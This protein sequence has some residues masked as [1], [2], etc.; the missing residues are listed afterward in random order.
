[1][2]SPR[3]RLAF[4]PDQEA[5]VSSILRLLAVRPWLVAGRDDEA[6][7][8][9]RRNVE[10]IRA[11]FGRLGWVVVMQKDMVRLLKS[12][13]PRL[14]DW[15]ETGPDHLTCSWFFLLAAAA[16]SLPPQVA[17]G[18]FVEAAKAAAAEADVPS[19]GDRAQ[20]RAITRAIR[21]LADRGVIEETDGRID[22]YL[23][24]DDAP[25]L[26]TI[27]H[28]R[29]LRLIANFDPTTDPVRE[30]DRWL[31][32]VSWERDHNR[33]MRRRLIDDTCVHAID[34]DEAEADWLSRRVRSDDGG[35]LAAAFGLAVE[36]RSE[37]AAFVLPDDAF[38]WPWE[39]GD[40]RY[41]TTGLVPHV[42][43][44]LAD[45]VAAEGTAEG[46]P[47]TGWRGMPRAEVLAH[48]RDLAAGRATGRGGWSAEKAADPPGLLAEV[49]VLLRA[50]GLLRVFDEVWWL[51]P[52]TGRWEPP[53][54]AAF[55]PA[56]A[57]AHIGTGDSLFDDI[58]GSAGS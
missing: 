25:V 27:F 48:L 50:V 53:P 22:A 44:L 20:R 30:P 36:R 6:I 12:P 32:N 39:L 38:R 46:G 54:N 40:Q 51:S 24:D 37:G 15:A 42:A 47:G 16:E 14:S 23:D 1:V 11:V 5:E 13:P 3:N 29:L 10:A 21:M 33:R 9:A 18:Q 7:S 45:I 4:A 35:P 34:L 52:A 31:G 17:I 2:S 55:A 8:A 28:T 41:P 56:P 57:A 49:E 43:T 26:L 19:P 58:E